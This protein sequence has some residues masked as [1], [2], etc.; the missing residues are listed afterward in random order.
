MLFSCC[1]TSYDSRH[2]GRVH[3]VVILWGSICRFAHKKGDHSHGVTAFIRSRIP[4]TSLLVALVSSLLTLAVVTVVSESQGGTTTITGCYQ[5]K[6]GA[7]RIVA[8][9]VPCKSGETPIS[10]NVQGPPGP[11]GEPGPAGSQGEIGPT[12]PKAYRVRRV[13]LVP[14]DRQG[15]RLAAIPLSVAD[16]CFQQITLAGSGPDWCMASNTPMLALRTFRQASPAP[17]LTP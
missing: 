9:S 5:N 1:L 4:V 8:E 11:Q 12:G 17:T 6:T 3:S 7:L 2:V 14:K 10:W 13:T 16:V 15:L